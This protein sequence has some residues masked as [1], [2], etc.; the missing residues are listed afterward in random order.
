MNSRIAI[1]TRIG[2]LLDGCKGCPKNQI[3]HKG[4]RVSPETIC[5]DCSSHQE[6]RHLGNQLNHSEVVHL[7]M[8]VEDYKNLRTT[9]KTDTKICLEKGIDRNELKAWKKQYA[10]ELLDIPMSG[11]KPGNKPSPNAKVSKKMSDKLKVANAEIKQL[12]Q[13]LAGKQSTVPTSSKT[14]AEYKVMKDKLLGNIDELTAQLHEANGRRMKAEDENTQIQR[15]LK[16]E[17]SHVTNDLESEIH[18]LC[19]EKKEAEFE[20]GKL[21]AENNDLKQQLEYLRQD[22]ESNKRF[23]DDQYDEARRAKAQLIKLEAFV[24]EKLKPEL[25]EGAL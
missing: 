7:E 21:V 19:K 11:P 5:K 4:N 12:K 13:E 18:Q 23:A 6:M 15:D 22:C 10:E 2:G 25:E 14:D 8:T 17:L 1:Y 16:E 3:F 24:V 20:T 9:F